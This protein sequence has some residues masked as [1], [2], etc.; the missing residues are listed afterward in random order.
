MIVLD[1]MY[2]GGKEREMGRE[3]GGRGR[4]G[5]RERWERGGGRVGDGVREGEGGRERWMGEGRERGG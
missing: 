5:E 2:G 1:H 4:V 3:D